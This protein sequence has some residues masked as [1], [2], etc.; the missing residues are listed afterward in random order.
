MARIEGERGRETVT[1]IRRPLVSAA[2][3]LLGLVRQF[4]GYRMR[5]RDDSLDLIPAATAIMVGLILI[6]GIVLHFSRG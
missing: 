3:Y 5:L 1:M 4:S 2:H 6:L